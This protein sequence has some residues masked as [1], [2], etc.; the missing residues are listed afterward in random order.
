[1]SD[2]LHGFETWSVILREEHRL[3]VLKNSMLRKI[4]GPKRD[5]VTGESRR[6]QNED[7]YSLYSL[8]NVIQVIKSRSPGQGV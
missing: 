2:V 3:R 5:N 1:L 4:S 6:L 7:L 8:P